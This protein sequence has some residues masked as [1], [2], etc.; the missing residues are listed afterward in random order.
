ME[1]LEKEVKLLVSRI[2]KCPEEKITEESNLFSDLG[3][4]SLTGVEIFA[5]LDKKYGLDIPESKLRDVSTVRDLIELV[6][7]LKV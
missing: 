3:V 4:D 2:A 7:I 1:N 5:A 6:K